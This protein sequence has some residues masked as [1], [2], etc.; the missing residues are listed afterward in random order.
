LTQIKKLGFGIVAVALFAAMA[1][2]TV[3][4]ASAAI[5]AVSAATVNVNV[6]AAAT[7]TATSTSGG[8][9]IRAA[10]DA[11]STG[12][13]E[14][15]N[16]TVQV[17]DVAGDADF[18]IVGATA[19]QVILRFTDLTEGG[20]AMVVVVNVNAVSA[21][22]VAATKTGI[23]IPASSA[24]VASGATTG[25]PFQVR[26]LTADNVTGT[27]NAVLTV[28]A[29]RGT[30]D[31]TDNTCAAAAGSQVVADATLDA[32]PAAGVTLWYCAPATAGAATITVVDQAGVLTTASGTIG[33]GAAASTMT[34]SLDGTIGTTS[35]VSATA[36]V[37]AKDSSDNP[38]AGSVTLTASP[39]S[40]CAVAGTATKNLVNGSTTFVVVSTGTAG[41]CILVASVT[42]G[43]ATATDVFAITATSG[44]QTPGGDGTLT[45]PSFGSGN[46]GQAVFDGGTIEQL[47]A[48]VVAAGGT[49]VWVQDASGTFRVYSTTA[50]AFVNAS[51]NTVF[52]D[53]IVGPKSV[54]VV[55]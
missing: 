12:S 50:P 3:S 28:S 27:S 55:K 21:T 14:F 52:A 32:A 37:A 35:N 10:V 31:A 43:T 15:A 2:A 46:V 39:A 36:T 29:S 18:I 13:V 51:F 8:S 1:L 44:G 17:A 7:I 48:Q 5:T 16:G 26:R 47:A 38:A 54:T 53:G 45:A 40:I 22:P 6:N 42:P 34:I 19:G 23:T 49:A 24:V 25:V 41:N 30:I 33:V 11:S 9:V 20:A 4:T